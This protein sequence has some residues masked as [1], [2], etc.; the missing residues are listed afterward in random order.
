MPG[1]NLQSLITFAGG[2]LNSL[3]PLFI[4]LA[5]VAFFWGLVKYVISGGEDHTQG[6]NIMIAGLVALFVMVSVWGIIRLAQN[7]LGISGGGALPA[8]TVPQYNN[9]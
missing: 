8:P 3:I 5:L 9:Q 2:I 1:N 6:R 7:T 4:A